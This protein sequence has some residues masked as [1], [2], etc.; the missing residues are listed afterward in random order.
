[1]QWIYCS[2]VIQH[3]SFIAE[4]I[5]ESCCWI[6]PMDWANLIQIPISLGGQLVASWESHKQG[7]KSSLTGHENL[8]S[9]IKSWASANLCMCSLEITGPGLS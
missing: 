7:M 8:R 3:K 4:D 9:D 2:D 6:M 5:K 1:M